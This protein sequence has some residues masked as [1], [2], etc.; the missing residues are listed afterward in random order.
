MSERTHNE[1]GE[2]LMSSSQ[3]RQA[4]SLD[5][6]PGGWNDFIGYDGPLGVTCTTC[7]TLGDHDHSIE[8]E[9]QVLW[10]CPRCWD[11]R[12]ED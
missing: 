6:Q 1:A 8:G 10:F 7:G 2:P 12:D 5:E 4:C 3:Y 11:D 9:A